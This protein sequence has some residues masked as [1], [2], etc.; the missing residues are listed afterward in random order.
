MI[1]LCVVIFRPELGSVCLPNGK[2]RHAVTLNPRNTMIKL[3]E[4]WFNIENQRR[5]RGGPRRRHEDR[6]VQA[7]A[8]SFSRCAGWW[9]RLDHDRIDSRT[10]KRAG[11]GRGRAAD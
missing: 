6:N 9:L 10:G 4:Y 5:P 3:L 2:E 8:S 11:R 7:Q 1:R